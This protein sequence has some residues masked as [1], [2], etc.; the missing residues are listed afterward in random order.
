[1]GLLPIRPLQYMTSSRRWAVTTDPTQRVGAR[2]IE[3]DLEALCPCQLLSIVRRCPVLYYFIPA[4][5]AVV[6]LHLCTQVQC[7]RRNRSTNHACAARQYT[8]QP[9]LTSFTECRTF[10]G[11]HAYRLSSALLPFTDRISGRVE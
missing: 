8:S 4:S 3:S 11:F 5:S 2:L 1:M 6:G 7:T 10:V 9:S